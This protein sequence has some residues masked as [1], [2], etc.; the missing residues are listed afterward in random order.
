MAEPKFKV[1][2]IDVYELIR[3]FGM[4][5]GAWINAATEEKRPTTEAEKITIC[6]HAALE[7]ALSRAA[8]ASGGLDKLG[9]DIL[10]K[11]ADAVGD[12]RET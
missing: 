2:D 10:A 4:E 6:V 11:L 12:K 7:H 3:A 1:A 8:E 9:K 5:R